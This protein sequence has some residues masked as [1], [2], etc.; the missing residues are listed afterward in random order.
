MGCREDDAGMVA[1]MRAFAEDAIPST[2]TIRMEDGTRL[3][4]VLSLK[5]TSRIKLS[6]G[7]AATSN[8]ARD[9]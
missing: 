1:D 3:E 2:R 6:A 4:Y 9:A 8:G 7:A 5:T